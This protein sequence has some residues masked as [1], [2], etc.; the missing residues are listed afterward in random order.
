M[1][2]VLNSSN[3]ST[4]TIE[5]MASNV[6]ETETWEASFDRATPAPAVAAALVH[7]MR[8]PTDVP[9][10]LRDDGSSIY[11]DDRPIGEQIEPGAC[12]S[13]VPRTHLG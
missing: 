11:L 2:R 7:D 5:F 8:L 4:Q 1:T 13:I 9:W 12:L 10:G 6:I 3:G